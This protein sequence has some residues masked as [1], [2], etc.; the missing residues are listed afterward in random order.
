MEV[1]KIEQLT[2]LLKST[3][4]SREKPNVYDLPQEPL[5]TLKLPR[6]RVQ[7]TA[8]SFTAHPWA[9]ET[10]GPLRLHFC[11]GNRKAPS[12]PPPPG[13]R[14]AQASVSSVPCTLPVYQQMHI[15]SF[16]LSLYSVL[17]KVRF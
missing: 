3:V 15:M 10:R 7:A 16:A 1:S 6:T 2:Y 12:T 4:N 11:P 13:S 8:G 17:L 5:E 14:A 9:D